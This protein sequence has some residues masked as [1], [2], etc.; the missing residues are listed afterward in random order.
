MHMYVELDYKI[1]Y[2]LIP[3]AIQNH[4]NTLCNFHVTVYTLSLH[5]SPPSHSMFFNVTHRDK[6]L[7]TQEWPGDDAT[8]ISS[9]VYLHNNNTVQSVHTLKVSL[10]NIAVSIT[11]QSCCCVLVED[12][13]GDMYT[14]LKNH[15]LTCNGQKERCRSIQHLHVYPL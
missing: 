7:K 3:D 1:N 9:W 2:A 15:S 6:H 14:M 12:T 5:W 13:Q 8:C 11:D 10:R 4:Q